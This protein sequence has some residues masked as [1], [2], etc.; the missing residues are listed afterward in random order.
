VFRSRDFS[1]AI[2]TQWA[3][4]GAMFGSFFLLPMFLQQVR[5][6]GSFETG[7]IT[8]PQA[9]ASAIFMQIGGRLFDRIGARPPVLAGLTL[10]AIAL[11]LM[12]GI[13]GSTTIRDLILPLTLMG[14]GMGL[15]MMSL[16]THMLNSAP[17]ELTSRVTALS[18][19]LQNVVS[20]L[21]IATFATVLQSRVPVH[22]AEAAGAAG[23]RPSAPALADA[24]AAGFGDVYGAALGLIVFAW[25]LA[26]TLRRPRPV[27]ATIEVA[28]G[29][30]RPPRP[31][32]E[33]EREPVVAGHL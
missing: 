26:W 17:R 22:L 23:G 31:D 29:R 12:T 10:V 3:G 30:G 4:F 7:L 20:S 5:G 32:A 28:V 16:S 21:A 2:A 13:T 9:V 8:L 33:P 11:G 14:A 27:A 15:M 19:A 1:L 25:L 6:Y 24:S 18:Q